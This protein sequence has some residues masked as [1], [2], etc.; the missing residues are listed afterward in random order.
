MEDIKCFLESSTIHGLTRI[1]SSRKYVGLFWIIV[2][3]SGFI[4]AG[5]LIYNSF[6]SWDESPFKTTIESMPITKITFPKVTVCPPKNTFTDLNYGLMM[7]KNMILDN[8]TRD[9]LTDY[10]DEL[11]YDQLYDIAMNNLSKLEVKDRYY[12]WYHGYTELE[13]PYIYTYYRRIDY[14]LKT[15][16]TSGNISTKHFGENYNA[17]KVE[18]KLFYK[19]AVYPPNSVKN[20]S[21]LTLHTKV[22]KIS[23]KYLSSGEDRFQ[24]GSDFSVNFEGIR[25]NSYTPP[26]GK[27]YTDLSMSLTRDVIQADVRKQDLKLMPGFRITWHYSGMEVDPDS[28]YSDDYHTKTF[29][30]EI[31]LHHKIKCCVN[32]RAGLTFDDY[33]H[34]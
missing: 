28:K 20:N 17:D 29:V 14:K 13:L 15:S 21:S 18:T 22:E 5:V 12:N 34:I 4:V 8:N 30:R 31:P 25:N 32:F 33:I 24:I 6:K 2:V 19:V 16:A 23:L 26:V 3:F 10:A 11:L 27:Y 1:S 7:T 9:Q